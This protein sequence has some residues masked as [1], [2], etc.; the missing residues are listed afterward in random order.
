M[1]DDELTVYVEQ[2]STGGPCTQVGVE[3]FSYKLHYVMLSRA[4]RIMPSLQK[5][6]GYLFN[7]SFVPRLNLF[8]LQSRR[9]LI[10]HDVH[11]AETQSY[12]SEFTFTRLNNLLI[13]N[14]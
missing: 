2:T 5:S 6:F 9:G 14:D 4:N 1:A 7:Y 8:S 13:N 11:D 3:Y 12:A 10:S